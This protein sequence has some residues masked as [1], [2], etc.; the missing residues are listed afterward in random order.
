MALH[1]IKR[2][3][4]DHNILY[5]IWNDRVIAD[6]MDTINMIDVTEYTKAELFAWLGY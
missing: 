5:M 2:I 6:D 4:S 1:T 3:L